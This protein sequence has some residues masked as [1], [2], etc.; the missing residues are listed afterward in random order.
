MPIRAIRVI[1][2]WTQVNSYPQITQNL[3]NLW[4]LLVVAIYLL[5][6]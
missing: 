3:R 4:M 5:K 6:L 2:G 1:R